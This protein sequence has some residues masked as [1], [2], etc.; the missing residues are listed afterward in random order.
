[1]IKTALIFIIVFI[2]FFLGTLLLRKMTDDQIKLAKYILALVA[3]CAILTVTVL[4]TVVFL[5]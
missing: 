5:F 4:M 1:M 2:S 3:Q